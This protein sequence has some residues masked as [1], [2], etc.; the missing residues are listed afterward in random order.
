MKTP[1]FLAMNPNGKVPTL[2][3]GD[4]NLWESRAI[5]QYV[6]S[7]KPSAFWPNDEKRRADIARWQFWETAHLS[8]GTTVYAFENLFKKMFY[9]QD[10][11]PAALA[12]GDKEWKLY[13]PV[14]N[15]QLESRKF[16]CGD[17][18]T[19]ADFSIGGCFSFAEVSGLPW[20]DYRHI[21]DVVVAHERDPGL[22]EHRAE[23]GLKPV[24][25]T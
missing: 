16:V 1:D 22:E 25:S 17:E 10:A 4:L 13:A 24:T 2:V 11:D 12:V 3:D 20:N 21:K 23:D 7:K 6:A 18:V 19:L 9:K 5:M 14:L 8:R 15:A